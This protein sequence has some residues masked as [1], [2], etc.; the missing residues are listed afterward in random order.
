MIVAALVSSATL[1]AQDVTLRYRWT[2]GEEVRYRNT[3][4]TDMQMSGL[5]GMG[6][7]TV[8]MTMVQVNKLVVDDIAADGTATIRSTTESIK[9]TMNIPMMGEVSYDSA[10]PQPAG[11]NPITDAL[12]QSVGA[13]VG[14]TLT[15]AVASSGRVG[16]IDGLARVVEKLKKSAPAAGGAMG[17]GNMDSFFSED[18]QRSTIEQSFAVMPDKPVKP[19]DTWKNEYKI[20][21][22]L[23]SQTASYVCTLKSQDTV[24]GNPTAR[25]ATTGTVKSSGAPGVMGPMTVTM[26]DGASQGE[27]LFD[28][29]LG[30]VR[31]STG[32]MTQPLAMKMNPGDGTEI[33]IQ[34]VQKTTSTMELI[35]K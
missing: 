35:E 4:Q 30:R 29:K 25:I 13:L 31:K 24:S 21:S 7:M 32:T 23:G 12:G 3:I 14:E 34:A 19:G 5:P 26:G 16:K 11:T 1:A 18:A 20:P 15:L 2:K 9:M 6:D 27:L 28:T 22:P 10:A 17:M 8:S 33:A